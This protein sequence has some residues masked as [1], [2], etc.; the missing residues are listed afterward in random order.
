MPRRAFARC[1]AMAAIVSSYRGSLIPA[2]F[3]DFLEAND[4]G[5]RHVETLVQEELR[6]L[7][8]HVRK[9]TDDEY[10]AAMDLL[11]AE[12]PASLRALAVATS[13]YQG[14]VSDARV[15][16]AFRLGIEVG[17]VLGGGVR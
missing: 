6:Q 8:E 14:N 12:M 4:D 7:P 17:R 5:E 2:F 1:G 3:R 9:M 10:W 13:D 11:S 15:D 16:V